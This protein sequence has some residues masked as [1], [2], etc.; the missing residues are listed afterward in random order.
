MVP[1]MGA[2][3]IVV[4]SVFRRDPRKRWL[5]I[6]T[7][8]GY[9]IYVALGTQLTIFLAQRMTR[10]YD[11]EFFRADALLG[12][13]AVTFANAVSP[14][15]IVVIVLLIAYVALPVVIGLA[16]VLEQDLVMRRA[17]LL[18]G[19][20]C[21]VFYGLFPAVGP[22][23]F[24]WT[25]QVPLSAP[26]NCMPSMHLTWALLIALNARSWRLRI[27]L[28]IYAASQMIATLALRE[29]YLVDLIAAVPYTLAIQ[30]LSVHYE[31]FLPMLALRSA[32][33]KI[34]RFGAGET[35]S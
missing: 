2:I 8:M 27:G 3:L 14:H 5:D 35:E 21:F 6:S 26:D 9:A 17:V 19:C 15:W 16:W 1:W 28:W 23:H 25:R 33:Q 18:A 20:I 34:S 13:N 24:D 7:L 12:F 4:V 32:A 29:H 10:T 31:S 11:A 30:W 22:G